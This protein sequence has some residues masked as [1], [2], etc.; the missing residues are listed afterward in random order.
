M[1]ARLGSSKTVFSSVPKVG[2]DLSTILKMCPTTAPPSTI[3]SIDMALDRVHMAVIRCC[4]PGPGRKP[5][6]KPILLDVETCKFPDLPEVLDI[7]G[8]TYS[9]KQFTNRIQSFDFD[10]PKRSRRRLDMDIY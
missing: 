6:A 3:R 7:V 9:V 4:H 1:A 2:A 10:A 8:Y 5:L